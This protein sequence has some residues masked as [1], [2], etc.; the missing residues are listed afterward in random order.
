[1]KV[2][3]DL[4][5]VLSQTFEPIRLFHNS[6]YD[7]KI[8]F[9]D[10]TSHPWYI[11]MTEQYGPVTN[12]EMIRRFHEFYE[13]DAFKNL[14]LV[15]GAQEG[16]AEL[17]KRHFDL[18]IITNRPSIL[19]G[20]TQQWL[21]KHFPGMFG[22]VHMTNKETNDGGVKKDKFTF[23]KEL[24][25]SVIIED[26]LENAIDCVTKAKAAGHPLR[27]ILFDRPWNRHGDHEQVKRVYSW[28]EA[29]TATYPR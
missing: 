3:V 4:D 9:E 27:A 7:T 13:T 21:G 10:I 18:D 5:D 22:G 11:F 26:C 19:H 8:K 17:K 2:G 29:V 24:G 14:A 16:I 6:K 25:I 23:C 15:K 28:P 20:A 1:M 12:E